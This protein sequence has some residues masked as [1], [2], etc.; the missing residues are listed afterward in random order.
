M[1][2]QADLTAITLAHKNDLI[3]LQREA[4]QSIGR[5]TQ[6]FATL[7]EIRAHVARILFVLN[8]KTEQLET[9]HK[10]RTST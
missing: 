3:E 2:T 5:V 6:A 1:V 4:L 7:Y 9:L 10:E 8:E